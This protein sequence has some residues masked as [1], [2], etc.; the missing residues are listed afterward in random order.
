MQ[1]KIQMI[2][3]TIYNSKAT[4]FNQRIRHSIAIGDKYRELLIVV[5][6]GYHLKSFY[7]LL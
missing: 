1:L 6:N 3:I 4:K 2:T 7:R 5:D